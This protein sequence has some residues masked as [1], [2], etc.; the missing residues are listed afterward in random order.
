VEKISIAVNNYFSTLEGA[1]A[2]AA[3]GA[4]LEETA[5][6]PADETE[7]PAE[8]S[9]AAAPGEAEAE[10]AAE[11]ALA[12]SGEP[13]ADGLNPDAE[14][15][16]SEAPFQTGPTLTGTAQQPVEDEPAAEEAETPAPA[17]P[18]AEKDLPPEKF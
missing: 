15:D 1:E 13:E 12:G 10:L 5:E 8:L 4:A 18:T 17:P 9:E 3:E 14:K 6:L 11:P 16:S 2:A 7:T